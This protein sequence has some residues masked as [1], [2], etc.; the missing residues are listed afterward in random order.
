MVTY[1]KSEYISGIGLGIA[2][3]IAYGIGG[4]LCEKIGASRSITISW[5]IAAVA[6]LVLTT[7]GLK[8]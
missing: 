3:I 4:I 7:Y 6:G 2:D 1:F 8:N 5:A